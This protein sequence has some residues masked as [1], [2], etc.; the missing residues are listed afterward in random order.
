MLIPIVLSLMLEII[1][2]RSYDILYN[3]IVAA[4][5][6]VLTF[7]FTFKKFESENNEFLPGEFFSKNEN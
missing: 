3:K 7:G 1:V 5:L 4:T 6:H 2:V